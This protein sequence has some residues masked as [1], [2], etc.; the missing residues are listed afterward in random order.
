MDTG[1]KDPPNLCCVLLFAYCNPVRLHSLF[2][3]TVHSP[4]MP[5]NTGFSDYNISSL[6]LSSTK[7]HSF[8]YLFWEIFS[9]SLNPKGSSFYPSLK[10]DGT[11][12]ISQT[13]KHF[14]TYLFIERSLCLSLISSE[15]CQLHWRKSHAFWFNC[16]ALSIE[17]R[18][19][20]RSC[21]INTFGRL[22]SYQ[23]S[24][25]PFYTTT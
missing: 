24:S 1:I 4:L 19:T 7:M 15:F 17:H 18:L 10:Q 11:H 16:I 3:H 21:W 8:F 2:A 25:S 9:G 12:G 20:N 23:K 5:L 13:N 22:I 14:I 6:M